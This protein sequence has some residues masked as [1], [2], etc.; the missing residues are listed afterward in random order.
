MDK[1]NDVK[2]AL[3]EELRD[4]WALTEKIGYSW[5]SMVEET[6]KNKNGSDVPKRKSPFPDTRPHLY[7]RDPSVLER[8][9]KQIEYGKSTM[10]YKRYLDQV[11]REDRTK[12]HPQTPNRYLKYS[13]RSWDAQIKIWRRQL[14]FWDPPADGTDQGAKQNF[15]DDSFDLDVDFDMEP[16]C[17][18]NFEEA[19]S[20]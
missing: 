5:S 14:H 1:P 10:G 13:R 19:S 15:S 9:Q 4:Y 3:D 20:T 16:Q 8:R 18:V 2:T 17:E 7:E 11:A 6:E 12:Q